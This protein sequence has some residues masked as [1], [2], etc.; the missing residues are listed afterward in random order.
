MPSR[1]VEVVSKTHSVPESGRK[2]DS[3]NNSQD[4]CHVDKPERVSFEDVGS[5]VVH[6]QPGILKRSS[7][8]NQSADRNLSGD[9]KRAKNE[10]K[11]DDII[12]VYESLA[13][14]K[15]VAHPATVKSY[16]KGVTGPV[17]VASVS[18]NRREIRESPALLPPVSASMNKTKVPES[19]P[20]PNV[21]FIPQSTSSS[22]GVQNLQQGIYIIDSNSGI[23]Q[24]LQLIS[25]PYDAF[26]MYTLVQK[27]VQHRVSVGSGPTKILY[28][29][30]VSANSSA[31]TST[32]KTSTPTTIVSTSIGPTATQTKFS[33]P[34]EAAHNYVE[35]TLDPVWTTAVSKPSPNSAKST[36]NLIPE[37]AS[38]KSVVKVRLGKKSVPPKNSA[39]I[40]SANAATPGSSSQALKTASDGASRGL[41]R[42]YGAAKASGVARS[43]VNAKTKESLGDKRD[44]PRSIDRTSASTVVETEIPPNKM[45]VFKKHDN[46]CRYIITK[47][48]GKC[49]VTPYDGKDCG[50]IKETFLTPDLGK[51]MF[52]SPQEGESIMVVVPESIPMI[53]IGNTSKS[54]Q[55]KASPSKPTTTTETPQKIEPPKRPP[56]AKRTPANAVGLAKK[57]VIKE[58]VNPTVETQF[59]PGDSQLERIYDWRKLLKLPDDATWSIQLLKQKKDGKTEKYIF[60]AETVLKSDQTVQQRVLKVTLAFFHFTC[61]S[62]VAIHI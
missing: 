24:H 19:P 56:M 45:K 36:S 11:D 8:R 39:Q 40:V 16:S 1:F 18:P 23:P 59:T 27:P 20:K 42:T 15:K 32:A 58:K 47:K 12:R 31:P 62:G 26:P 22:S 52:P 60:I 4:M 54:T 7:S 25:S 14:P 51:L 13:P 49:V 38:A 41:I 3:D 44:P 17:K 21:K 5:K 30:I 2:S 50:K 46:N 9:P 34:A 35:R 48:D 43:N 57:S 61:L 37:N 6:S 55:V 29:R 28:K 53:G 10:E 33:A